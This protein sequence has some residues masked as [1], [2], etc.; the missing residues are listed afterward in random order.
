MKKL[1][2]VSDDGTDNEIFTIR[3]DGGG[4][5]QLTDN[6]VGDDEPS[7]S[8]NGLRIAYRSSDGN[9]DEIFTMRPDGGARRQITD[10]STDDFEPDWGVRVP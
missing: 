6:T 5:Q 7:W 10:N 9:D 4:R 8:P 1:V 3:P 2:Y